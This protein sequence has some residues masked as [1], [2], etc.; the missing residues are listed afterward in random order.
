MYASPS[1]QTM[2]SHGAMSESANSLTPVPDLTVFA[3]KTDIGFWSTMIHISG[4]NKL[5][6]SLSTDEGQTWATSRHLED[7][8]QG[9]Y[10]YPCVI[11]TADGMIHCVYSYFCDEGKTMK[12]AAFN[13]DWI[14]NGAS[15][16]AR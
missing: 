7:H 1:P 4:R 3:C 2:A 14:L 9:S 15:L 6:V 10:H 12:H 8:P 16:D 13:E 5:A 11:Q